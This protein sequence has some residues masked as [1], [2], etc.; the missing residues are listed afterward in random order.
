MLTVTLK[1]IAYRLILGVSLIPLFSE[2]ILSIMMIGKEGI[3]L[4]TTSEEGTVLGTIAFDYF[5]VF[6]ASYFISLV[7]GFLVNFEIM[8]RRAYP[9]WL[10]V[11]LVVIIIPFIASSIYV[12]ILG[13]PARVKALPVISGCMLAIAISNFV[14]GMKDFNGQLFEND[15]DTDEG[16]PLLRVS[17][18][19]DTTT[20]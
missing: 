8:K 12:T 14:L 17:T 20:R 7:F 18:T 11:V 3:V 16:A 13:T 15:T 19:T 4:E 1:I 10:T 5:W 6:V 9:N 2:W